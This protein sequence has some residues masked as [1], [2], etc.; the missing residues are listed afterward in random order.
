LKDDLLESFSH[1][2][3][4]VDGQQLNQQLSNDY[5]DM[6]ANTGQKKRDRLYNLL[7]DLKNIVD[8]MHHPLIFEFATKTLDNSSRQ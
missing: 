1:F 2:L 5:L 7:Q 3:Q 8:K 4:S 6:I